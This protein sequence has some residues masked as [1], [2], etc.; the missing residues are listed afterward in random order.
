VQNAVVYAE[1][2]TWKIQFVFMVDAASFLELWLGWK[3]PA[4]LRICMFLAGA[5]HGSARRQL[6]GSAKIKASK[7]CLRQGPGVQFPAGL[8]LRGA[9]RPVPMI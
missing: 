4:R 6:P 3:R 8:S 5:G 9:A 7:S 2:S 1:M